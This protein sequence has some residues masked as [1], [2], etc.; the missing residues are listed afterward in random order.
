MERR[1]GQRGTRGGT[2]R[3]GTYCEACTRAQAPQSAEAAAAIAEKDLHGSANDEDNG[4]PDTADQ[5]P[6]GTLGMPP[7]DFY[8][9]GYDS[10][11]SEPDLSDSS[12]ED[13]ISQVELWLGTHRARIGWHDDMDA[14]ARRRQ[15]ALGP[16]LCWHVG[17][18]LPII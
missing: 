14:A 1:P 8:D 17:L 18:Q 4:P 12:G 9:S 13:E 6:H 15:E 10:S 7:D 5:R 2:W 3:G 11:E 16:S